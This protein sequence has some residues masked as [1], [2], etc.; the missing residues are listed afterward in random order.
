[1]CNCLG[2]KNDNAKWAKYSHCGLAAEARNLEGVLSTVEYDEKGWKKDG[3]KGEKGV[4]N[5]KRLLTCHFCSS[6]DFTCCF[7]LCSFRGAKVG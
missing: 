2:P 7:Q 4:F 6:F 3:K 5:R 1:M